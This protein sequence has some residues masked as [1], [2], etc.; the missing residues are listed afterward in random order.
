MVEAEK[1]ESRLW[2]LAA[3]ELKREASRL[4]GISVMH[5]KFLTDSSADIY[6]DD[7]AVGFY[8]R[9]PEETVYAN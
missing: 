8:G 4:T 5:A 3:E 2:R 6:V 9:P 7:S 1:A